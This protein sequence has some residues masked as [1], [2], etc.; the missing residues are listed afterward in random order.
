MYAI[1][2]IS[3]I[4]FFYQIMACK[5]SPL[6]GVE[7]ILNSWSK[8]NHESTPPPPQKKNSLCS[9]LNLG[10]EFLVG[11]MYLLELTEKQK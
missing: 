4:V 10:Y 3:L 7:C 8:L 5:K 6:L 2:K 11:I 9:L 1:E